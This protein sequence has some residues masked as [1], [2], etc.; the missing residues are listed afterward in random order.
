MVSVTDS[1]FPDI[2]YGNGATPKPDDV[3]P[4]LD[5]NYKPYEVIKVSLGSA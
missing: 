2:D 3:F 4:C 1:S 5:I